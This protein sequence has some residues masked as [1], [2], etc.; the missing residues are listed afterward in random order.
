[1]QTIAKTMAKNDKKIEKQSRKVGRPT[2]AIY[3]PDESPVQ[4]R[5]VPQMRLALKALAT[6]NGTKES[7]EV[8]AAIREYLLKN[9]MWPPKQDHV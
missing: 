6:Q 5:L 9:N 2:G 3:P 8:R 1:M 7:E 4:A